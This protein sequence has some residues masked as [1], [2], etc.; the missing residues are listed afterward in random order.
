MAEAQRAVYEYLR[1]YGGILRYI[2]YLL[3]AQLPREHRP[4]QAHFRRGLHAR[5]VV[6]AHLRARVQ[7]YVRQCPAYG[8]DEAE[9]LN[10]YPVRPAVGGEARRGHGVCHFP[11]VYERVQRHVHLAPADAAV[12]HGL[13]KFLIREI[14]RPAA[15]VEVAHAEIYGV[16]A[17]LH[18][19][20][21]RLRRAGG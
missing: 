12:G 2:F 18:G 14:L 21:Y 6:Y 15:G 17:V 9:I 20:Y 10:Y 5:K 16:R 8:G 7:R 4:R 11:V 19:G 13:F 1:L 3:K